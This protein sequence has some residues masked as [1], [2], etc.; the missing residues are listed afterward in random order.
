M[1]TGRDQF[2]KFA[3][4][5]SLCTRFLHLFPSSLL[6]KFWWLVEWVPGKVGIGMRYVFA[7]RLCHACGDNVLIG[8]GV[9]VDHWDKL[10]FGE[11]VTLHRNCYVD[12]RGGIR[13]GDNVSIAHAT[14]LL[15]FEHTW[16]EVDVPIKYNELKSAPIE[17]ADD[18]WIG[19]GVRI[20]SGVR[21][22]RR[23]VIAAGAVVTRGSIGNGVFGG[24][25]AK[26]LRAFSSEQTIGA[27]G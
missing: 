10:T 16:D 14:S 22:D 8:T 6:A 7:K 17:I 13:I 11:N 21:I 23:T 3:P 4:A 26:C 5:I 9:F 1:A 19:C 20:L 24:V 15:A 18:V 12:A 25:P 27:T 2:A